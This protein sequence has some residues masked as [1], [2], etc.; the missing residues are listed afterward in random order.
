MSWYSQCSYSRF[1][2][3]V[4]IA[5]RKEQA[6]KEFQKLGKKMNLN[7]IVIP[8]RTIASTFWGKAWCKQMESYHDY[9]N[10]L[11]RGRS[12]VRNG[13]V[14]DLIV[15]KG[16]V[17]ALVQGSSLYKIQVEIK[18][19]STEKWQKLISECSGKIDSLVELLQGKFSKNVMEYITN[20]EQGLF[21]QSKEITFDCSC[22]DYA[23]MCKHVAAVLYG[24]GARLD[25]KPEELFVL[26]HVDHLELI[27]SSSTMAM[28]SKT[29]K[30]KG[31]QESDFSALFDIEMEE[32]PKPKEKK[33]KA[34]KVTEKPK[35]NKVKAQKV[36]VKSKGKKAKTAKVAEKPKEAAAKKAPKKATKKPAKKGE[37][38]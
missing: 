33:A 11:P 27:N 31:I 16:V 35:E 20:K 7:P 36:V 10:R 28:V 6:A 1:P 2:A 22:P 21:P 25:S 9:E 19:C 5:D 18:P 14:F 29:K 37:K 17:K 24:I 34:P 15:E 12:Y 38:A 3:Y 32:A 13:F 4:T 8:G 23:T 30:D 26:R